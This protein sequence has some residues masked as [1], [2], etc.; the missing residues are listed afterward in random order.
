[1]ISEP[2]AGRQV[3]RGPSHEIPKV[4]SDRKIH[5]FVLTEQYCA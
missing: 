4:A 5:N 2:Y 3:R 1:M